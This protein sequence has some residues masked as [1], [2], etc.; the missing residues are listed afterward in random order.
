MKKLIFIV[1]AALAGFSVQA[2]N[3]YRLNE[4]R[5]IASRTT[6]NAEGYITHLRGS[7]LTKG[8]PTME[9][10]SLLPNISREGNDFKINGL[11]VSEVY[12]DGVRLSDLSE[13]D[14][15]PGAMI[16]KV[17]VRYLAGSDQN[18][19]L[20]GGSIM[21]TLRK[22]AEGGYYGSINVN[23]GWHRAC[24][25]GNEGVGG[26]I[27]YR[28]KNLSVYDNLYMGGTK[29]EDNSEQSVLGPGLNTLLSETSK[30]HGFDFRNRLSLTQQFN[31]GAQLGGSYLV[32]S[33]RP[34]ASS[35]TIGD[36]SASSVVNRINALTQEGTLKLSLP[37]SDKGAEMELTADYFN[38]H[39]DEYS[40]YYSDGENVAGIS[41]AGSLN[42]WMF[43]ADFLHPHNPKLTWK[44]GASAQLISAAYT[45][46]SLLEDERFIT[47][48]I[49][50]R[51][52]GFTPMV[53]AAAQGTVWKLRYSAG[54]NWQLNSIEYED[55]NA[56]TK[57]HNTQW[58]INPTVQVMMPFGAQADHAFMLNYKRTLSEIPYSAISSVINWSDSY[59]YSV[60]NPDLKAQSADM[61]MAAV[62]LFRNKF[63]FTALYAYA[64]DR[65]Y[66]QTFQNPGTPDV[67]Y[68]KPV[69]IS[70]QGMWGFGAE[71]M[72]S[73]LKWWSFKLSGRVEITPEDFTLGG[74]HYDKTRFREYFYFNNNFTFAHGWGGMLNADFEPTFH[75]LDRTY[76]AVY[77]VSGRVYK[78]FLHDKFQVTLD[79]TALG[80][81]RKLDRRTGDNLVSYQYTTPVQKIGFSLV[82][83]FSG[84]RKVNVDVVEG[85]QGYHETKDVK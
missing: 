2:Q 12:V 70:G 62:S 6:K 7:D 31:S 44:L 58:S 68:T 59:N 83:N 43:K 85:I 21:I 26:L 23:A 73:P 16:D 46:L 24:G 27:N 79:F 11:A 37:L 13:L 36:N 84:G 56:S 64:H 74:V 30:S 38:R 55:L 28:Y 53:Y 63:N 1:F 61:V 8:K 10:L 22:P 52:K 4:V 77:N 34:R 75:N 45:P 5:I 25:F 60:G 54:V 15:I 72:P 41:E 20:S 71:W 81:R 14:N 76:H 51:T 39:S 19:A 49:P 57:N 32:A 67:F 48:S 35:V 65:I 80:N 69:N 47:S 40:L 33:G 82:W 50:T 42:L 78:T 3:E 29:F 66:W 17:Q 18:A 9:L